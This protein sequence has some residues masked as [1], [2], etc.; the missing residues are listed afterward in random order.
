MDGRLFREY[1]RRQGWLW[2]VFFFSLLI[3][4]PL[5]SCHGT[6]G[7][8]MNVVWA[9]CFLFSWSAQTDSKLIASRSI[10]ALPVS[11]LSWMR[12]VW[13]GVLAFPALVITS[14]TI[15]AI[16]L[17]TPSSL[18]EIA[19][20]VRA[21]AVPSVWM[22]VMGCGSLLRPER[23]G[24]GPKNRVW[25]ITRVRP[26]SA[27]CAVFFGCLVLTLFW[28]ASPLWAE[29]G[30]VGAILVAAYSYPR[31][32]REAVTPPQPIERPEPVTSRVHPVGKDREISR[33]QALHLN[34]FTASVLHGFYAASG[35]LVVVVLLSYTSSV[36]GGMHGHSK[37][38]TLSELWFLF[39]FPAF[40][41]TAQVRLKLAVLATLPISRPR[42]AFL[43]IAIP[44]VRLLPL[45]AATA[46]SIYGLSWSTDLP[47][48]FWTG[49]VTFTAGIV[50]MTGP[51]AILSPFSMSE[52]IAL[53]LSAL[54]FVPILFIANPFWSPIRAVGL[55]AGMTVGGA[56]WTWWLLYYSNR[57]WRKREEPPLSSE[58]AR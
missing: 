40:F 36:R 29:V 50:L 47:L 19:L 16:L 53:L 45:A 39:V 25:G 30:I 28:D 51:M 15:L 23:L 35:I 4:T 37:P 34:P 48:G 2:R 20:W 26:L 7:S 11:S 10:R 14:S 27:I 55:G 12:T 17:L 18:G 43:C 38:P 22:L 58:E 57:P 41:L 52:G 46:L 33:Y 3:S 1:L 21:L 44:I 24:A 56:V 32:P 6:I 54:L 5:W 31:S 8:F 42:L 9:L 49:A 13:F